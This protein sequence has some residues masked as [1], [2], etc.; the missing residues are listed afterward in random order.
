[1]KRVVVTTSWDDGHKLD[2]KL[3]GLLEKY[4]LKGTFYV[5]PKNR[6]FSQ[7]DL[8]TEN[9]I[10]KL[11][12]KFEIG[13]HT[14]THPLL[15]ND[16]QT[17]IYKML[18]KIYK[19]ARNKQYTIYPN[20]SEDEA[21]K[22]IWGSKT[23]L[24]RLINKKITSFCYPAGRHNKN[25][26]KLVKQ[27]GFAYA[28]TVDE[29][30]FSMP[31]NKLTSGTSIHAYPHLRDMLPKARFSKWNLNKFKENMD[32]EKLAKNMFDG[33]HR[34]GGVF[35]LWGHSWLI[36]EEKDWGKLEKVFAYISGRKNVDYLTNG[37]LGNL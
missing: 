30:C 8:L 2:L 34:D 12:K 17:R 3:A 10:I 24:E 19:K 21:K 18:V 37:Q 1:M 28:R 7:K 20:I 22:E 33:V 35:H 5:A 9:Q 11:S 13:A 25:I 16:V 26:E 15:P 31:K 4:S 23:Y 32:W 6:E 36:D 27:A 14:L 29:Y